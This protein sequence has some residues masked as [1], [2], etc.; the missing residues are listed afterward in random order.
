MNY[1]MD[2]LTPGLL[3]CSAGFLFHLIV[4][5]MNIWGNITVYVTSYL[6]LYNPELTLQD[7]FVVIPMI[8]ITM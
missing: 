6:R 8:M 7:S 4:G 2:N 3:A 5:G 1:K